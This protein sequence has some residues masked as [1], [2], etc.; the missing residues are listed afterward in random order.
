[1]DLHILSDLHTEHCSYGPAPVIADVLVLAGDIC[2][3]SMFGAEKV[4]EHYLAAKKPVLYV[5]G[6]HEFYGSRMAQQLWKL[7]RQC[8][9]AGIQLMHNREVVL[10]GVRVLGATLWTDFA[11]YG[12]ANIPMALLQ[13]RQM[14]ADF[15]W[16]FDE[17]GTPILPAHT[18]AW[19]TRSLQWLRQRMASPFEGKTVVVTHH[20][21]HP[22]SIHARFSNHPIN[23]AFV[24]NLEET[25]FEGR[26]ALWVHGHVHNSFDYSVGETRVVANPRGYA[27]RAKLPDGQVVER[28]ENQE[29]NPTLVVRV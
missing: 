12:A 8:R 18:L 16:V 26:P 27:K 11:L 29:F 20:G 2:D 14:V 19:H 25:L 7:S 9:R 6:N 22:R 17:R 3:A 15:T 10:E 24:S 4:A 23:T 21:V 13:A 1:M 5:P 28:R